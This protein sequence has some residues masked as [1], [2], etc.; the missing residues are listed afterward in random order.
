MGKTASP[1]LRSALPEK[2]DSAQA[3]WPGIRCAASQ[4]RQ[5]GTALPTYKTIGQSTIF[6]YTAGVVA[7]GDTA[8]W[9][10]GL[11]LCRSFGVL[12]EYT[13]SAQ[14]I[15]K[16][17]VAETITHRAWRVAGSYFLT[18]KTNLQIDFS[19]LTIRSVFVAKAP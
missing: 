5:S 18:G 15:Q 14:D 9:S 4:G 16:A 8:V 3:Q 13:A 1:G 10:T 7:D 11:L 12:A 17:A 19:A 6:S 2:W